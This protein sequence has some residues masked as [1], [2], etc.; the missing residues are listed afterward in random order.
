MAGRKTKSGAAEV[1]SH[2]KETKQQ[3]IVLISAYS[4]CKI[5]Q[6]YASSVELTLLQNQALLWPIV[7]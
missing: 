5:P 2:E 4:E 6:K 1:P 3:R 7:A